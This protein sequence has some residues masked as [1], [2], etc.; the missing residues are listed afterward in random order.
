MTELRDLLKLERPLIIFDCETTGQNPREDRI[1]ELGFIAIQPDGSTK[2]WQNYVNPGMP[3]PQEATYGRAGTDYGGHGITDE[4]VA[5]APSFGTLAPHLLRGFKTGTDYGG[6]NVKGYDLP[7]MQA[8]FK[9]HGHTWSYEDACILDGFRMWQIG[10]K[11]TLTD[12]VA[13]FLEE[14][15][16]GAHGALAD[17]RAS[18]R[19]MQAQL[20]RFTALP[21]D[22]RAL[23]E[24]QWPKDPNA[25]DPEGKIIWKD[26]HAVMNFGKNW[27]NKRLDQMAQKDLKWIVSPACQGASETVKRICADALAGK[28]P[29]KPTTEGSTDEA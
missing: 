6:Y 14:S 20:I 21:R 23:H 3:I 24:L 4:M 10:R 28:F 9:R 7:L 13:E 2:E 27:K 16:E 1:V 18:L 11:R 12:A 17:V 29:T 26:G 22:V 19:V 15:H 25:I 5:N 8:E